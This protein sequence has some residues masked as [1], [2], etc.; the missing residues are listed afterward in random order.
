MI[1]LYQYIKTKASD[2]VK[3]IRA[4]MQIILN[5]LDG[6]SWG[7]GVGKIL[8]NK[9]GLWY[10]AVWWGLILGESRLSDNR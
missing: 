2:D 7:C 6:V 3:F 5:N 4:W 9:N 8:I 10:E 1:K